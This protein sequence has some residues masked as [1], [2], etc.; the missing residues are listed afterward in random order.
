MK[1]DA[2]ISAVVTGAAAG[3]G[4]ATARKLASFG[5]KVALFDLNAERGEAVAKEIGMD[6]A[7]LEKDLTSDEIK[8]TIDESM[9]IAEA[10][11]L[12][13]TPSYVV[14]TDIVIGA[15]GLAALKDKVETARR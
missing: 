6:M 1:L 5:V 8:A 10:L 9:K 12:N 14:G 13:G 3:L 11:G 7:R 4:E 15:V 2:T